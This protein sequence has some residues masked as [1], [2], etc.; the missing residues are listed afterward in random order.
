MPRQTHRIV[1]ILCPAN[2][3]TG[4]PEALHQLGRSLLDRGHDARMVYANMDAK[5]VRDGSLLRFA[6]IPNPAPGAYAHYDM[7]STFTVED[8]EANALVFPE[9]WIHVTR[10]VSSLSIYVWW[11]SI[12]NGRRAVEAYGGLEALRRTPYVNLFQSHYAQAYLADRGIMG[13]PLYDYTTP[14]VTAAE[15]P[16]RPRQDRVLYP[17]R[18]AWFAGYLRR[19]TPDLAWQ[20]ISGFT[21][22][23]VHELFLTSKLYVD[24]GS[25]PGKDRMPREAAVL[26]CCIVTGR[27]GAAGNHFD[28]PIPEP[29]KFRDSRLLIPR[30]AKV[31]RT[32]LAG[33]ASRTADFDMYRRTIRGE[34]FEFDGQVAA[35]FGA[36]GTVP[37]TRT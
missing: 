32:T 26:G 28:V 11:L 9:T 24:F 36:P 37:G 10:E 3:Q 35:I 21:P 2:V 4:G 16:D 12:D 20:E 34:K 14:A 13:L 31:I 22:A 30:I 33:F 8:N 27:R 17:A 23:Q 19:F 25:H 7:P 6:D 1:Y 5:P 29:Y 18:G 15:V